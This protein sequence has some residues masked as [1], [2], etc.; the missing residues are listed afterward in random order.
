MTFAQISA[1]Q[2]QKQQQRCQQQDEQQQQHQQQQHMLFLPGVQRSARQ[3]DSK[4]DLENQSP[5]DFWLQL[6]L[7]KH[8]HFFIS[9]TF[10]SGMTKKVHRNCI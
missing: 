3:W 4:I 8:S 1:Q 10:G 9:S 7:T 6:L 5:A 2:Q